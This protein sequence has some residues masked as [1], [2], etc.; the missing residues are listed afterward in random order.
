MSNGI[1]ETRR[2]QTMNIDFQYI[3]IYELAN[4]D[5]SIHSMDIVLLWNC[6][7]DSASFVCQAMRELLEQLIVH[8]KTEV[9]Y[10]FSCNYWDHFHM[11][12]ILGC[13]RN[14]MRYWHL[15]NFELNKS[16]SSISMLF[17]EFIS[18]IWFDSIFIFIE[19]S[20]MGKR[21]KKLLIYNLNRNKQTK[22]GE[23]L[24]REWVNWTILLKIWI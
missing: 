3:Y 12:D 20:K 4:R 18:L 13:Y 15:V 10:R 7:S 9:L 8:M 11:F 6:R 16:N 1:L 24:P 17:I 19:L 22:K 2:C 23:V 5:Y 14:K 21:K